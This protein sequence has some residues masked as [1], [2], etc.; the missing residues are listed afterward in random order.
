MSEKFGDKVLGPQYADIPKKRDVALGQ[1]SP[2][3]S[4]VPALVDINTLLEVRDG[5]TLT[6]H[7]N[8]KCKVLYRVGGTF[9]K[10]KYLDGPKS[11]Q[12]EEIEMK[13]KVTAVEKGTGISD[14]PSS[15]LKDIMGRDW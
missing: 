12:E 3:W 5:D 6:L 11:K 8:V 13:G 2:D 15:T 7:G 10:V 4:E 1:A 9:V 14:D